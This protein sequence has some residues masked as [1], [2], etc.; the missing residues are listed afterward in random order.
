LVNER[1]LEYALEENPIEKAF[2]TALT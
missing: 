2:A 1:D